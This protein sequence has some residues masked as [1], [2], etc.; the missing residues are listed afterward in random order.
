MPSSMSKSHTC[1]SI[2]EMSLRLVDGSGFAGRSGMQVAT[3]AD[4]KML[5][6]GST[7]KSVATSPLA[8][9]SGLVEVTR[10]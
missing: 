1:E 4:S 3:S 9:W 8:R 2:S 10:D 5:A 7:Y 6:S